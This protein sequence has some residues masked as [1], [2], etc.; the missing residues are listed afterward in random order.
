[1]PSLGFDTTD[2]RGFTGLNGLLGILLGLE[3]VV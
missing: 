1:M 2:H 3:G